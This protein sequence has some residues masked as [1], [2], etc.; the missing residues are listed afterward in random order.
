MASLKEAVEKGAATIEATGEQHLLVRSRQYDSV[1]RARLNDTITQ[2]T[3]ESLQTNLERLNTA[4]DQIL[5]EI[6]DVEYILAEGQKLIE[7]E[8]GKNKEE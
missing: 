2:T 5:A 1:T 6:A 4:K 8:F 3:I 7:K